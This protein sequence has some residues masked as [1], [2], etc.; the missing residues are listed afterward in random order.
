[1]STS[2]HIEMSTVLYLLYRMNCY[3]YLDSL[4][5]KNYQVECFHPYKY[6]FFAKKSQWELKEYNEQYRISKTLCQ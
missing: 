1:M 3:F 4:V 2:T 5:N 6:I